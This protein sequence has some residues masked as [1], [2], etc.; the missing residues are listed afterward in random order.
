MN[1]TALVIQKFIDKKGIIHIGNIRLN[2][3]SQQDVK[4]EVAK[5]YGCIF[6][7]QLKLGDK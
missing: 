1:Y 4:T 2:Q 5:S 3:K 7:L 6:N